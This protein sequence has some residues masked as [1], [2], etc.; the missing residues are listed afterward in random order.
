MSRTL[1]LSAK[2]KKT[3]YKTLETKKTLTFQFAFAVFWPLNVFHV[4]IAIYGENT[5]GATKIIFKYYKFEVLTEAL[6]FFIVM[7][8]YCYMI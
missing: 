6:Y 8:I 2:E 5:V 3:C 1:D 4:L 7:G